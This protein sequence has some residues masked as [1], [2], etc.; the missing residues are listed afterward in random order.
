MMAKVLRA[1][2]LTG[3]LAALLLLCTILHADPA[4][5]DLIGPKV[6]VHVTRNGRT[7]T[8][9]DIIRHCKDSLA[10]YKLPRRIVFVDALPKGNTGKVSKLE[11]A[12]LVAGA[13]D[14]K[15]G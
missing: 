13:L 9:A 3:T 8:E 14:Q 2:W 7:T 4:R 10:G 1:F 6:D 11:L 15:Q 5:F 12:E